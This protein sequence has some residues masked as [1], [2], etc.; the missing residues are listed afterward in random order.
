M[1]IRLS[2]AKQSETLLI[3]ELSQLKIDYL[4]K[5]AEHEKEKSR[6]QELE[7]QIVALSKSFADSQL[8]EVGCYFHSL[9]FV[10]ISSI[11]FHLSI[12]HCIEN[13]FQRDRSTEIGVEVLL[14]IAAGQ[15]G[16]IKSG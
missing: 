9:S 3:D 8:N 2:N 7:K 14:S 6:V 4:T 10:Y 5:T 16:Q 11:K 1:D 15:F 13:P 12:P